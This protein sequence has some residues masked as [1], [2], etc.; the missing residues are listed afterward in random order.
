MEFIVI[1]RRE[2]LIEQSVV[3]QG[4]YNGL[5]VHSIEYEMGL[6]ITL[7]ILLFRVRVFE[8]RGLVV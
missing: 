3:L 5:H 7:S 8:F 4:R 2:V 6:V 1:G